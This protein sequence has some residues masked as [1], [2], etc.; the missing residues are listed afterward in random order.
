M[1][2]EKG[3]TLTELLVGL[4]VFGMAMAGMYRLCI[5]QGK[6]YQIQEQVVEVQ[7]SVRCAMEILLR[8][9]R[10]AGFDDEGTPLVVTPEP[11]VDTE[12]TAITIRYEHKGAQYEVRYWTDEALR[13]NR[14]E[15][16]NG[17]EVSTEALLENVES[18]N[19]MYAADEDE[20]GAMDDRNG[21]GLADDWVS[22]PDVAG[23][24]VVAVRVSSG[25]PSGTGESGSPARI[26]KNSG[27]CRRPQESYVS[28][29]GTLDTDGL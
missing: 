14:R 29:I 13:L 25:R 21:N 9:I 26:V 10:M 15:S 27:L 24:G 17:V 4:A 5:G 12:A 20:D 6:A 8:D 18:L 19:F 16:K 7:Q 11:C 3:V 22:A 1:H 28:K 2:R 23:S